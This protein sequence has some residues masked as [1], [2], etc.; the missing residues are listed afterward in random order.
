LKIFQAFR[1]GIEQRRVIV[2]GFKR[3]ENCRTAFLA[4]LHK[5]YCQLP[6]VELYA[7]KADV[8][9]GQLFKEG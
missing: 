5:E 8:V 1:V 6:S 7:K 9:R 3:M 4:T 2:P